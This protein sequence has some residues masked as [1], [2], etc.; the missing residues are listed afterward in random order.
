MEQQAPSLE[1]AQREELTR[2]QA[3]KPRA[4]LDP[5]HSGTPYI[6]SGSGTSTPVRRPMAGPQG[7]EM[8]LARGQG[9]SPGT[10]LLNR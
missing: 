6:N 10:G 8:K 7:R 3:S 2:D 5:L 1:S 9:T 4:G